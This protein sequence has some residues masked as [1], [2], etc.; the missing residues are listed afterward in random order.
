MSYDVI[1]LGA[2][3]M[4]SATAYH[5]ARRGARVLL[6]EQFG[7]AHDQG[8]SH[9][10]TRIIRL[11]Y[12]EHPAYVVLL[13]RAYELW[14]AIEQTA[15]EQLFYRTGSLDC[16]P[17]GSDVFTGSLQSCLDY[18]LPHE[19]LTSAQVTERYPA[20]RLPR[21]NLAVFQ[22]DGGFLLPER[23]TVAFVEAAHALG[24]EI[25]GREALLDWEPWGDG[26][27]VFTDRD[28]Y[29]ADALVF[30]A[31]AWNQNVLPFLRGLAVPERQVLAWLQPSRPELFRPQNFPV[32]N[33]LV[34][35]GRYYGF[36]VFAV[37]GFKFGRYHHFEEAGQAEYLS[38][39]AFREDEEVLRDFAARY[40]PDGAGPTMILK[41]CL[42]TN[43]PDRHFIIDLHPAYP[44]VA[45]AAGFSG[46]GFKFASV[47]GEIMADLAAEGKT[48]YPI[49]LFRP[50]RFA[51]A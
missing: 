33:A 23:A 41:A 3:A 30:T 21:E 47:V 10:Y 16:G 18:D 8:S 49:A 14:A 2:G 1:V 9:G 50:D 17:A 19:I 48:R 45:I 40:F 37:P 7:I 22:P 28:E 39:E 5:L 13:R 51:R 26:V 31:G 4:G 25:H 29:T 20:Y 11:A 6:L 15:G 38:R 46:H 36:P 12:Y 43:S 27:R 44:Q 34:P 42:F 35:E 24:A 32:F